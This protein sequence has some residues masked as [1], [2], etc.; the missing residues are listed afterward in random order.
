MRKILIAVDGS[1]CALK[2]VDYTAHQFSGVQDLRITLLHVLPYL[3]TSLWDDGHI[4]TTEEREARKKV[5]DTWTKNQQVRAE[6]ILREAAE[7]LI[8]KGI[9]PEQIETKT[10]SDSSDVAESILEE[11]RNG[12]YQ[13]LVVGRCGLTAAKRFL[14]GSVTNKILDHGSGTAICVVE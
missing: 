4:L 14:M 6:P 9:P 8:G 1:P 7:V 13:T 2:A 11:T 12:G 3:A 10:I 5:V